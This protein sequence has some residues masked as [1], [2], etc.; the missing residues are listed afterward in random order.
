MHCSHLSYF[1]LGNK[2]DNDDDT[3]QNN[4]LASKDSVSSRALFDAIPTNLSGSS[5]WVQLINEEGK[6]FSD[7]TWSNPPS[8]EMVYFDDLYKHHQ[9]R[10]GQDSYNWTAM[11]DAWNQMVAEKEKK[12]D[13]IFTYKFPKHL[14]KHYEKKKETA[15]R[16]NALST[17]HPSKLTQLKQ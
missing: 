13:S 15:S 12:G 6:T 17:V 4:S 1:S 11:A 14:S 3:Q 10:S 7:I 2:R 9:L 8:D 16:V 5:S